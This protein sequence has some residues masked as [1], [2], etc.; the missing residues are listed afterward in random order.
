MDLEN[1]WEPET[2]S[3]IERLVQDVLLGPVIRDEEP[4]QIDELD[5]IDLY[6]F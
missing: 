6:G 1:D 4:S 2:L 3:P 5:P